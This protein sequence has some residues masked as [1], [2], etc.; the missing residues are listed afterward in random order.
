MLSRIGDPVYPDAFG[1]LVAPLPAD[2]AAL[3]ARL[4]TLVGAD[5]GL[6]GKVMRGWQPG[7]FRHGGAVPVCAVGPRRDGV[8]LYFEHGRL[9][10]NSHG[11]LEG[12]GLKKGRY[13]RLAPDD[14]IPVDMIGILLSEAIALSA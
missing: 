11:L 9:L 4:V 1:A 12:D 14:D 7:K 2:I 5:P 8:A 3:T 10:D 6:S 13:L